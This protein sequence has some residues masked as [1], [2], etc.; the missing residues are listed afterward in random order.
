MCRLVVILQLLILLAW[1]F[2]V[3]V[4]CIITSQKLCSFNISLF[5]VIENAGHFITKNFYHYIY[6]T[7]MR[8]KCVIFFLYRLSNLQVNGTACEFTKLLQNTCCLVGIHKR[9][10][11][12]YYINRCFV[13]RSRILFPDICWN[14]NPVILITGIQKFGSRVQRGLI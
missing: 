9:V 14:I 10:N 12:L 3:N 2:L 1:E 7:V 6:N 8:K 4:C 11:N 13:L 5:S